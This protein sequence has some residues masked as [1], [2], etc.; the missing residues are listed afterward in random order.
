MANREQLIKEAEAKWEREQ[1]I[2]QAEAKWASENAPEPTGPGLPE[3]IE[4]AGR[5]VLEGVTSGISEPAIS[6]VNA[7]LGNLIESGFDAESLKDFFSK[8]IDTARIEK[9]F[10]RDVE[11]RRA[12]EKQMPGTAL[13]SEIIGSLSPVGPA[14]WIA[15]GATKAAQAIVPAIKG[16]DV[17]SRVGKAGA[18]AA[19]SG[20]GMEAAKQAAQVPTGFITPEEQ[21]NILETGEFGAKIGGGIAAT[22]AALRGGAKLGK[23]TLGALLGPSM[24]TIE[25]YLAD[26][27]T[28]ARAKSPAQIKALV[29]ETVAKVEADIR[30]G[31]LSVEKAK[32]TLDD[33]KKIYSDTVQAK[34]ADIAD[35]FAD[36]KQNLRF[37]QEEALRP[38]K[39]AR[40]P[41]ELKQDVL[42]AAAEIKKRVGEESKKS[43]EILDQMQALV[44]RG[45][46]PSA[47]LG[48]I[49]D[50]IKAIQDTLRIG[51]KV[52]PD[53][54][55]K[56]AFRLLN[57]YREQWGH[58]WKETV[59]WPQ[60]KQIVQAID[61]DIRKFSDRQNPAQFSDLKVAKLMDLR[62]SID[63]LVKS[64]SDDLGLG[65]TK[66]M[67][68]VSDLRKLQ[69]KM[70]N[71]IGREQSL[72]GKLDG[73]WRPSKS[74]DAKLLADIGDQVGIDLRS[75][76]ENYI[77]TKKTAL[78]PAAIREIVEGLPE[79]EAL[80]KL[81]QTRAAIKR[82]GGV[83]ALARG[84]ARAVQTA[85]M[86]LAQA[87]ASAE[88]AQKALKDLGPFARPDSNI[89]AI[90]TAV[91][92]RNPQ[93]D[94]YLKNLTSAS[95]QDFAQMIDDLRVAEGFAKEFTQ[96]SK[97]VNLFGAIG[98]GTLGV[99]TGDPV[100]IAIATGFGA[101]AGGMMD[102][103]GG[104]VTQLALDGI[105]KIRGMPTVQKLN[106]ALS[107]LPDEVKEYVVRDLVR[108]ATMVRNEN[109]RVDAAQM[110]QTYQD[111]KASKMDAVSKSK[112]LEQM[113]KTGT[114]N[115]EVIKKI[116]LDQS[117]SAPIRKQQPS[118][119]ALEADKPDALRRR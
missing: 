112:A 80:R 102:R 83:E 96:G 46:A 8:S 1:L 86:K 40:P 31:K 43:Y 68:Q 2:Q 82:P 50:R 69:S 119:R 51:T 77:Q 64:T 56:A 107:G 27:E 58:L 18:E 98:A 65:Y 21:L 108:A 6:G 90:R 94:L 33:A 111:I 78:N 106:Q 4:T 75:P 62:T 60:V 23:M 110:E 114:I 36:A 7:V 66:Q 85:E 15:K 44:K 47:N 9:E 48:D 28:L 84:E 116:M 45:E 91:A 71:F 105:I 103:F 70:D 24:K 81:E 10:S 57:Q 88:E 38:I 59:Q 29:D 61:R 17:V 53:E 89:S 26:P 76:I 118:K 34:K 101:I 41:V 55:S 14:S 87:R 13:T 72:Q 79:S 95:G 35:A 67:K 20:A 92:E 109:V 5:S 3:T 73:I 97:R 54:E 16:V 100:A 49:P 42:D 52:A 63:N 30:D 32:E 104:K 74:E 12:L 37:A 113:E 117:P 115:S 22:G 99:A 25:K 19:L 93:Y 11:R 39:Q